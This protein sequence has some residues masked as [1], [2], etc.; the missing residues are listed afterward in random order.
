MLKY[1]FSCYEYPVQPQLRRQQESEMKNALVALR[2]I[3]GGACKDRTV[4]A[5]PW[6]NGVWS[7]KEYEEIV[8]QTTHK[9]F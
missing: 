8:K 7:T 5:Q 2:E 9:I 1:Y 3:T 4:K 6:P